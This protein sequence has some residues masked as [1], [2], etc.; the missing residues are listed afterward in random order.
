MSDND[1][2]QT[3]S[4]PGETAHPQPLRGVRV[5]DLTRVLAGPY[6]TMILADLGAEVVKVEQ[7]ETGDDA[8]HFGPFLPSGLSGYFASINRGKKSIT[9]DLKRDEDRETFLRLVEKADVLVENFRPGTMRKLQL[10]ADR[11]RTIRPELIYASLSG[12]GQFGPQTDRPAYDVIVQALSGLMSITG[13]G[14]GR[15]VRVGTSITDLLTGMY[16][17]IAILAAL[18]GRE[19]NGR[20]CVIDLAMLDCAVA[21]LENAVCRY[22]VTGEVPEPLGGRHPSITP[23]QTF[24]TAD[25]PIVVAAGNDV[26]WKK[27]CLL[28]ELPEMIDDPRF[29][30][31][32]ARTENHTEME[33]LL[34]KRFLTASQAT[35]LP[36]LSEAGIPAAPIRNIAAVVGDDHLQAREALHAMHD[37]KGHP[38]LAAGS[39]LRMN[40]HAPPLAPTAPGLGADTQQVLKDWLG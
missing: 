30:T 24:A 1:I 38:F 36:R 26:L 16:G 10:D 20:G 18:R 31:N 14:P 39:P 37:G 12:F 28:V 40:G 34:A 32:A 5:L 8:R 25:E 17:A 15:F 4:P 6:C 11:L 23:F 9:L 33:R 2:H 3:D 29:A 35:W 19:T 13:E 22:S 7:P 27:L 21:A